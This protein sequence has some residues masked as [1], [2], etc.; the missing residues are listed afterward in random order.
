MHQTQRETVNIPR[1]VEDVHHRYQM[2]MMKLKI[3]GKGNGITT[4]VENVDAIAKSLDRP[5]IYLM[6]FLEWN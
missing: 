3:E 5:T 1:S 6:I 2:P 4:V